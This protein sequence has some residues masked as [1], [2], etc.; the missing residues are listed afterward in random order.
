MEGATPSGVRMGA[1]LLYIGCEVTLVSRNCC[2][3][4]PEDGRMGLEVG[5][6]LPVED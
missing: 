1:Y 5:A 4:K 6:G 3:E 2:I